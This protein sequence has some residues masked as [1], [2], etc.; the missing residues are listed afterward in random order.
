MLQPRLS[1]AIEA[2]ADFELAKPVQDK[3][4]RGL[5]DISIPRMNREHRSYFRPERRQSLRGS[6]SSKVE[7]D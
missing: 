4:L 5:L 7:I 6:Y 2:G 3:Q 1:K